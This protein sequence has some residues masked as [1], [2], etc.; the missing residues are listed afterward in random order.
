ML[1]CRPMF[2]FIMNLESLHLLEMNIYGMI[3]VVRDDQYQTDES[4]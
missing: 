1:K 2:I 3:G 4:E